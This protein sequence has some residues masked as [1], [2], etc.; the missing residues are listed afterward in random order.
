M[1][2]L[3]TV[4]ICELKFALLQVSLYFWKRHLTLL[5]RTTN[6]NNLT[7]LYQAHNPLI[8]YSLSIFESFLK[9]VLNVN[10]IGRKPIYDNKTREPFKSWLA[11]FDVQSSQLYARGWLRYEVV[12]L[13]SYDEVVAATYNKYFN[14][15][16]RNFETVIPVGNAI[17]TWLHVNSLNEKMNPSELITLF[18]SISIYLLCPACYHNLLGNY[19]H[20]LNTI[21]A[22][23]NGEAKFDTT[24]YFHN[25]INTHLKKRTFDKNQLEREK[26]HLKKIWI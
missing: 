2:D 22:L 19:Q 17:W 9:G 23:S 3:L 7:A 12:N 20:L 16:D 24:V 25:I 21:L 1:I 6:F 15:K 5:T 4:D 10:E 26:Q 13:T 11:C 18:S 8:S 14:I